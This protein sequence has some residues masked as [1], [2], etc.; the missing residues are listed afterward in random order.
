VLNEIKVHISELAKRDT[1][2]LDYLMLQK[3]QDYPRAYEYWSKMEE[4]LLLQASEQNP[5]I[6]ELS[7]LFGR[8]P[9]VLDNKLQSLRG[10][11]INE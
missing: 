10:G 5:D 7:K 3:R 9:S 1:K 6:Q 2:K 8:Q 4:D 11:E